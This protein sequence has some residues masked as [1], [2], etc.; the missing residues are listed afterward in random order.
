MKT[1]NELIAAGPSTNVIARR[2]EMKQ[3][4]HDRLHSHPWHQLIFPRKGALK[5][6]VGEQHYF[7]PANRAMFIPANELH[8]SWAITASEFIGIYM[9]PTLSD[10]FSQCSH[11]LSV[12]PLLHALIEETLTMDLQISEIELEQR[13]V[14]QVLA[15]QIALQPQIALNITIPSDKR[16]QGL[17]QKLLS[18]PSSDIRLSEVGKTIG[19]S[20]K[21]I[22]RL[23]KQQTGLSFQQW[24]KRAKLI[25]SLAELEKSQPIHVVALN[26]GYSSSASYIHSFKKEFGITPQQ[27]VKDKS[28]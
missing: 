19:A 14:L 25:V 22:T 11:V 5:T 12:S 17:A 2:I 4:E 24:K 6:Q 1:A 3:G 16:I 28:R 27:H 21:T 10:K 8:E 18:E 20:E 7:L 26:L 15:D 13:R 9:A 23:F